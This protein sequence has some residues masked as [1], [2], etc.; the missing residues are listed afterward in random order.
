M[1]VGG[2]GGGG[3]E[4]GFIGGFEEMEGEGGFRDT[5]RNEG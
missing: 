4:Q 1:C 2:S 3:F 5:P